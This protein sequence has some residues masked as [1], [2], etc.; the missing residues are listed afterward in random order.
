[1]SFKTEKEMS[2]IFK[3]FYKDEFKS[4]NV[5]YIE[6]CKGLFGIPDG[7]LVEKE[8]NELKNIVAIEL[9]LKNWKRALIQAFKYKSFANNSIVVID[10]NYMHR[11][12]K[13]IDE[14]KRYKIG[15]ASFS[16]DKDFV[17]HYLPE[18]TSPFSASYQAVIVNNIKRRRNKSNN[19]F[20]LETKL[21]QLAIA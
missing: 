7:L 10:A 21:N 12:L 6:E 11:A 8:K 20:N 19:K 9:K 5:D 1:M 2:K 14:F 3:K 15:L 13:N 16:K 18:T 17:I 4:S